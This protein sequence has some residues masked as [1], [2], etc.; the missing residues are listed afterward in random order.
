MTKWIKR[1]AILAVLWVLIGSALS[2]FYTNSLKTFGK[3]Q[4]AN[5]ERVSENVASSLSYFD[6]VLTRDSEWTT[7]WVVDG[8]RLTMRWSRTY[9]QTFPLGVWFGFGRSYTEF[10]GVVE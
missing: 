1:L 3:F 8:E 6:T 5:P 2:V 10:E 4:K 9:L 7:V